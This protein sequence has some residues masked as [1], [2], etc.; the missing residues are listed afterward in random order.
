M[1]A[2]F[3]STQQ[4]IYFSFLIESQPAR[5]GGE[6]GKLLDRLQLEATGIR[7]AKEAGS[8]DFSGLRDLEIRGQAALVRAAVGRLP[9]SESL[10]IRSRF[11]AAN[12]QRNAENK[13]VSAGYT[14]DRVNALAGLASYLAPAYGA[15][16]GTSVFLLVAR[17]CG[18]CEE[19]KPTYRAMESESKVSARTLGRFEEKIKKR[20]RALCNSGIESL[21]PNFVRDGLVEDK[22]SD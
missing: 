16:D 12:P 3:K 4:A 19:L 9:K 2:I 1:S 22:K 11:G 20:I 17:I 21:T 7:Q 13:I 15:L 18:D 8:I 6:L 5:S 14:N 10:A